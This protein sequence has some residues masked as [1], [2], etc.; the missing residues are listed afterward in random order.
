MPD[1]TFNF[2]RGTPTL[3]PLALP[4]GETAMS[5]LHRVL[6]LPSVCSKRFLTNKVR[7][8]CV[9]VQ[10]QCIDLL[11]RPSSMCSNFTLLLIHK[12]Q[13]EGHVKRLVVQQQC[14]GLLHIPVLRTCA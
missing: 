10:Q 14:V 1:K 9:V 12:P 8:Q 3:A 6:R 5:A 2:T 4:A 7:Q 11:T 13:M